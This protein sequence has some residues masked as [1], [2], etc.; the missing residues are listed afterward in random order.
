MVTLQLSVAG[1]LYF[2]YCSVDR[3]L[4]KMGTKIYPTLSSII[5]FVPVNKSCIIP[6]VLLRTIYFDTMDLLVT[7]LFYK[8]MKKEYKCVCT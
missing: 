1:F 3:F 6:A 7:I 4:E 5:V 8:C 2:Q